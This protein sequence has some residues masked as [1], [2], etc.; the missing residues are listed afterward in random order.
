LISHGAD[1]SAL[2]DF[3]QTPLYFA[4]RRLIDDLGLSK[5]MTSVLTPQDAEIGFKIKEEM[6]EYLKK[7]EDK[8]FNI[9]DKQH[10]S[11]KKLT[12]PVSPKL[13]KE[14]QKWKMF[15]EKENT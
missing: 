11:K 3:M 7:N 13:G 1:I 12:R 15:M 2:N 4:S 10:K 6:K 8:K 9:L 14:R 5:F